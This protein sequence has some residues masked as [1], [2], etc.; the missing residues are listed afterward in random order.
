MRKTII[1]VLAF[2]FVPTTLFSQESTIPQET[3]KEKT[4]L[5]KAKAAK[6]KAVELKDL[7]VSVYKDDLTLSE[8]AEAAARGKTADEMK[9]EVKQRESVGDFLSSL[10]NWL[11]GRTIWSGS[12]KITVAIL[13][14]LLF[15]LGVK[16]LK[17][18]LIAMAL[19]VALPWLALLI[20][21]TVQVYNGTP[22]ENDSVVFIITLVAGG[23]VVLW[24]LIQG[25]LWIKGKKSPPSASVPT[26]APPP[27][28]PV[29]T[30]TDSPT[31]K[32]TPVA[33]TSESTVSNPATANCP[34]CNKE[35]ATTAKFCSGC[36][37]KILLP[38]SSTSSPSAPTTT[39]P[40]QGLS[41][42][43]RKALG[44]Y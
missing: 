1:L 44:L 28:A 17:G 43:Q 34:K 40:N 37:T 7:G 16:E 18:Q 35:I 39:D 9:E 24:G 6:D 42:Q 8:A 2:S 30:S 33:S 4:F 38:T 32:T 21:E 31:P 41:A 5:E 12:A 15:S 13:L 25:G 3:E 22:P 14:V 10:S 36:G 11:W 29:S 20:V 27:P 19:A 23:I 26:P